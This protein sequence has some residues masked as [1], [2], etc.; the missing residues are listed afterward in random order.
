MAKAKK[1]PSGNWRV[2]QYV[3]KNKDG[4]RQY[5]SFTAP[6]KRE[7]EYLAAEYV[8]KNKTMFE[9][10]ILGSL[11]DAYIADRENILSPTTIQ[12]Y[13]KIR[14][15]NFQQLMDLPVDKIDNTILQRAIN[16]EATHS[17]PKS[18]ANAYGLISTVLRQNT[19][20]R[21]NVTLPKK[22]KQKKKLPEPA[23]I[24]RII[25]DTDIEL[26]CLLAMWLSF[27]MS[28]IKGFKKSDIVDGIIS[29]NR[30]MVYVEKQYVVKDTAKTPGSKRSLRLPNYILSLIEAVPDEQE[31]LID[32]S[33]Q[34]IYKRFSRL[35]EK[36]NM[37]HIT[38]HDLR[39]INAS[40]MMMLNI[41]D[42]YAMERGGW[43]TDAVY[44]NVYQQTF[45][46]ERQ[47]VDRKVDAYFY[48]QMPN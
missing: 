30:V 11:I 1:L 44:K 28:E 46:R 7:A 34:A 43:E 24:F 9:R 23:E 5:K 38:F 41:P 27:R 14:R 10:K 16:Q 19:Y 6:S 33:G 40:V 20:Y 35:L 22:Q 12:G 4:K 15:N 26:P 47:E 36:N 18:V 13:R 17:S 37:D 25:K 2:N 8:L 31:Y 3:G 48:S 39:H 32:M 42:K 21:Y 45:S 29:V